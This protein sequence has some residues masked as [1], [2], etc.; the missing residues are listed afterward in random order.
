MNKNI[1]YSHVEN[2]IHA[3]FRNFLNQAK[4]SEDVRNYFVYAVQELID[5]ALGG[6]TFVDFGDIELAGGQEQAYIVHK[7]LL[8]DHT[9]MDAWYNTDLPLTIKRLAMTAVKHRKHF[10]QIPAKTEA[11]MFLIPSHGRLFFNPARPLEVNKDSTTGK[12]C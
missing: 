3:L 5:K 1:S 10:A 6:K 8:H 7:R 12:K 9:F 11:E 4:S 2:E